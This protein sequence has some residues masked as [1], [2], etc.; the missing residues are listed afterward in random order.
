M[1]TKSSK[2]K[3][4]PSKVTFKLYCMFDTTWVTVMM[5]DEPIAE[6]KFGGNLTLPRVRRLF[7]SDNHLFERLPLYRLAIDMKLVPN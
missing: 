4:L 2:T 6:G 3:P 5:G 1:K 7:N